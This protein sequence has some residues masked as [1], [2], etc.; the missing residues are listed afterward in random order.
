MLFSKLGSKLE[1]ML[2]GVK[3]KVCDLREPSRGPN[4]ELSE[5]R[6]HQP[7]LGC[8]KLTHTKILLNK[9]T[10]DSCLHT[11]REFILTIR[12]CQNLF[13]TNLWEPALTNLWEFHHSRIIC[14]NLDLIVGKNHILTD[15]R[16]EYTFTKS[17]PNAG[18]V[19]I[20]LNAEQRV[21]G[22]ETLLWVLKQIWID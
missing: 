9:S 12:V 20:A 16:Q 13:L 22:V 21:A 3:N 8:K 15:S 17:T 2:W 1:G 14:Q 10:G 4:I 19:Q 5:A 6:S 18:G 7:V 11:R